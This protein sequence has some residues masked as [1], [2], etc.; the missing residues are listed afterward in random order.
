MIAN[1]TDLAMFCAQQADAL[2]KKIAACEVRP[3]S[4]QETREVLV[5]VRE[6]YVRI[7]QQQTFMAEM[8][9]HRRAPWWVW[10]RAWLWSRRRKA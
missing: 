5:G 10:W 6:L 4:P 8:I 1:T 2:D 9:F 7:S 3:L